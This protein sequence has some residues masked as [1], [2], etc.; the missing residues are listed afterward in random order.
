[1]RELVKS[2]NAANR[3]ASSDEIAGIVLFL[4]SPMA[5]FVTGATYAVD[6]GQSAH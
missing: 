1:M 3:I 4:A 2:F 6:G 5:S